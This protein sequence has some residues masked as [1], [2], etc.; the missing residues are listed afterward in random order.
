M[1][2]VVD[3]YAPVIAG[4]E[5]DVD[6]IE[7]E[8]FGA[9][10]DASQRIYELSREV[11]LFQRAKP[12]PDMLVRLMEFPAS[13]RRSSATCATSRTMPCGSSSRPTASGS[14]CRTSSA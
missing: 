9:G 3:D 11:L 5:N 13:M 12:L 10:A 8:V 6:E 14:C 4:V 7:D 1:D 2:R